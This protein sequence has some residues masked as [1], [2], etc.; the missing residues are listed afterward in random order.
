MIFTSPTTVDRPVMLQR[1]DSLTFVHWRYPAGDVQRLLPPGLD[2]DTF[3]GDAWVGLVPFHMQ[4]IRPRRVPKGIPWVGT[5]PETN[6]R[7]YV[8]GPDGRRGVYFNSLDVTRLAAVAVARAWYRLPYNWAKMSIERAPGAVTYRS[9][10]RWPDDG[11]SSCVSV[12]VTETIDHPSDLASFLTGRWGLWTTFRDHLAYAPV[13]HPPWPLHRAEVTH[14]TEDLT[15]AAGLSAPAQEPVVY[16][17]PGVD[18][19]IGR[20]EVVRSAS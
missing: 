13:D 6:I 2:V 17:S 14:L 9:R 4:D 7:T 12:R 11:A 20:P 10:R 15:T 5:F 3:D 8:I 1:W 16:Y 18:V 19:R